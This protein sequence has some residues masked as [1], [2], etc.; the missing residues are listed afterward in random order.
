MQCN[1]KIRNR[2]A[3]RSAFW[4][5]HA[6]SRADCGALAAMNL[7]NDGQE[8]IL[9]E[10]FAM[11]KSVI[12]STRGRARSHADRYTALAIVYLPLTLSLEERGDPSAS[13]ARVGAARFL[14]H[15]SF[16]AGVNPFEDVPNG[17]ASSASRQSPEN[18]LGSPPFWRRRAPPSMVCRF[19]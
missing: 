9:A 7:R 19:V 5:A 2:A 18:F 6:P 15:V 13:L 1:I 14:S 11:T 16:M 17:G 12:A 4:G 10:K 8:E 3:E